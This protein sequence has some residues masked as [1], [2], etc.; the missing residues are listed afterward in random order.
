MNVLTCCAACC[1]VMMNRVSWRVVLR[2]AVLRWTVCLEV[3]CG[4]LLCYDEPCVLTCCAACCCVTMNRVSRRVVPR[5]AVLRWTVCLDVLCCGLDVLCCVLLCYDEPCVLTSCVGCCCVCRQRTPRLKA[6]EFI[7]GNAE[8]M[9]ALSRMGI[10]LVTMSDGR[11]QLLHISSQVSWCDS[12][13]VCWCVYITVYMM[14]HSVHKP[15]VH[16]F[17]C[18]VR[19]LCKQREVSS[20]HGWE[21]NVLIWDCAN[22]CP[23]LVTDNY[24][25]INKSWYLLL[26]VNCHMCV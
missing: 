8:H 14:M 2:V 11:V 15:N 5:V 1:C 6:S 13:Q 21:R 18:H 9:Q 25:H 16:S 7:A 3:L 26:K 22:G 23:L 10:H 17:M 20:E 24:S 4:V 19:W 12:S